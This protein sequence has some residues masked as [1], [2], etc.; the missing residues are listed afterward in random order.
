MNKL[1]LVLFG[2]VLISTL[3][4]GGFYLYQT[5]GFSPI[6]AV[7]Q[8]ALKNC[9]STNLST[10]SDAKNYLADLIKRTGANSEKYKNSDLLQTIN[11][12]NTCWGVWTGNADGKG[13]LFWEDAQGKI[14]QAK[15]KVVL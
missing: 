4:V 10:T 15:T 14:Y 7:T 12:G 11:L 1:V 5:Q 9:K 2:I 3:A 8:R 13:I 6:T